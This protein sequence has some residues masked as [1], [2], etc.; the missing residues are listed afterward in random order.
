MDLIAA[1]APVPTKALPQ[2]KAGAKSDANGFQALLR[3]LGPAAGIARVEAHAPRAVRGD[4]EE[5]GRGSN[6]EFAAMQRLSV[7]ERQRVEPKFSDHLMA[8]DLL[9]EGEETPCGGL[10][11]NEEQPED[12]EPEAAAGNMPAVPNASSA[13][14]FLPAAVPSEHIEAERPGPT[15]HGVAPAATQEPRAMHEG[16]PVASAVS[17]ERIIPLGAAFPETDVAAQPVVAAVL[18]ISTAAAEIARQIVPTVATVLARETYFVPLRGLDAPVVP[19]RPRSAERADAPEPRPARAA[20]AN[21]AQPEVKADAIDADE[22]PPRHDVKSTRGA[23]AQDVPS[24]APGMVPPPVGQPASGLP[25]PVLEQIGTAIVASA[26][27]LAAPAADR[28]PAAPDGMTPVSLPGRVDAVEVRLDLPEHGVL[29]VRMT[30]AGGALSLRLRADRDETVHRLRHDRDEL[31]A[32]LTRAGYT[33][34]VLTIQSRPADGSL[35]QSMATSGQQAAGQQAAADDGAAA[36]GQREQRQS[37]QQPSG[38]HEQNPDEHAPRRDRSSG[39][40]YV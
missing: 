15:V 34:D 25:T 19:G 9:S 21:P 29:H 35:S 12:A 30:L 26:N 4:G 18:P 40:L 2:A 22:A 16:D 17:T 7:G 11:L 27:T 31:S 24:A 3:K 38:A 32:I 6:T 28:P 39:G 8:K 13:F 14:L 1:K 20:V 10:P 36:H 37:Q 33:A 5:K 23:P